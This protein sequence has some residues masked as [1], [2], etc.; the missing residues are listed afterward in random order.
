[1]AAM[2]RLTITEVSQVAAAAT[3]IAN[4]KDRLQAAL[5]VMP[6][7]V[8]LRRNDLSIEYCNKAY[9]DGVGGHAPAGGGEGH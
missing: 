1:M 4:E 9:A 5:D 8:W 7:P 2:N 3:V 6:M